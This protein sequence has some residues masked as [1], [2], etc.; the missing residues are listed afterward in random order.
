MTL[1]PRN[2]EKRPDCLIR[3]VAATATATSHEAEIFGPTADEI[4]RFVETTRPTPTDEDVEA[5]VRWLDREG[6][7]S[8]G[9]LETLRRAG[10]QV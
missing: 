10:Y 9:D 3:P 4:L 7:I 2:F 5:H 6:L 8:E 1:R